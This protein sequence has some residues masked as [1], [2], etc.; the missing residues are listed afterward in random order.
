MR[1]LTKLTLEEPAL[2]KA[3][4]ITTATG[5][6]AAR[7]RGFTLVE[8]LVALVV[9]TVGMLGVAVLYVEGLRLN[10]T[11]IYRTLAVS[12]TADM[13][14][15]IRANSVVPGSY[16]GAGPG[17][18]NGCVNG[19]PLCTPEQQADDDWFWWFGD[20][21]THLPAGVAAEIAVEAVPGSTMNRY[22]ISLS[23]AEP[24]QLDPVTY[25]LPIQL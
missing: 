7:H 3:H 11:S 20:A 16:A 2:N 17:T 5:S 13:A 10:R 9:M 24:G 8:V 4:K 14:D 6:G 22:E 19:I 21:Q 25:T 18:D 23:W 15:R 1:R 12:L